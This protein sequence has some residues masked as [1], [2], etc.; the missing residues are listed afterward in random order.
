M[1]P[2]RKRGAG[3]APFL[4]HGDE[5]PGK[6]SRRQEVDLAN[7]LGGRRQAGSGNR[8]GARGDVRVKRGLGEIKYTQHASYTLKIAELRK[9]T[10]EAVAVGLVPFFAVEFRDARSVSGEMWVAVPLWAARE[11][12]GTLLGLEGA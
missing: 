12:L 3:I 11:L 6:A 2:P 4:A 7:T 9:I 5:A 8:A 10:E 1:N